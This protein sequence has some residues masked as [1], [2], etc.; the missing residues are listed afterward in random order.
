MI[1][2]IKEV[3]SNDIRFHA[4]QFSGGKGPERN[5]EKKEG[6]LLHSQAYLYEGH[7]KRSGHSQDRMQERQYPQ[8]RSS[9]QL[10]QKGKRAF[11]EAV[12]DIGDFTDANP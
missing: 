6:Y 9:F 1:K 4:R 3:K 5:K 8:G 10:K 7:T 2:N 11:R 12:E